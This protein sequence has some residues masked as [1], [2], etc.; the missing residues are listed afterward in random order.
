[1]SGIKLAQLAE[2]AGMSIDDFYL[3]IRRD[4]ATHVSLLLDDTHPGI[5]HEYSCNF[6]NHRIVVKSY[7]E[8]LN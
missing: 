1:M 2:D 5:I 3:E 4:Y 7:K 8:Q 6:G